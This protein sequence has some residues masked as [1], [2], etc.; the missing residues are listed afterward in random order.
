LSINI[1]T[2]ID[3]VYCNYHESACR[4]IYSTDKV[5]QKSGGGRARVRVRGQAGVGLD[6]GSGRAEFGW[7]GIRGIT[8][9]T[10]VRHDVISRTVCGRGRG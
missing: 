8:G 4:C 2:V 10:G 6:V 7:L 9:Q 5:G 1:N 3:T